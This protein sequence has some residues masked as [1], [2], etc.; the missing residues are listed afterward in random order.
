[1]EKEV[2]RK[3]KL[4]GQIAGRARNFGVRLLKDGIS[5]FEVAQ[6]IDDKIINLGAKP[7]FPTCISINDMAALYSPVL[8]DSLIIKDG[9][10]IKLD[11]GAHLDGYLSDTAI[12]II[13]GRKKDN[14][15]EC[16]EKML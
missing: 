12:T 9:D 7:A 15:V 13:V 14:I 3:L 6:K 8:N 1:M 10:Y 16:S 5:A 4:S 11:L 2:L